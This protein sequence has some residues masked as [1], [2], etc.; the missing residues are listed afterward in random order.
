M[1]ALNKML[2]GSARVTRRAWT[3]V[4]SRSM[5]LQ[6]PYQLEKVE[7]QWAEG[8]S[9]YRQLLRACER[10]PS[11]KKKAMYQDIRLD[12][13]D[14]KNVTDKYKLYRYRSQAVS[15]LT[16]MQQLVET[17]EDPDDEW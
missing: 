3:V 15:G 10:Y 4:T 16:G 2:S 17:A 6:E 9:V 8:K 7:L 13:R 1:A 5:A 11:S 12:F 14:H